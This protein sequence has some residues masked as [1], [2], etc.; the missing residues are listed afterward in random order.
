MLSPF[1]KVLNVISLWQIPH[2]VSIPFNDSGKSRQSFYQR[3]KD[4]NHVYGLLPTSDQQNH[5]IAWILFISSLTSLNHLL[6][7]RCLFFWSFLFGSMCLLQDE[8]YNQKK[9]ISY[10]LKTFERNCSISSWQ[11]NKEKKF[12]IEEIYQ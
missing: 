8:L 2:S 4:P 11:I 12:L 3:E 1:D 6:S 10:L 5:D 7:F 9:V